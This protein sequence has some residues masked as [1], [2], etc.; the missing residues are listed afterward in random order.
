MTL[1]GEIEHVPTKVVP[2]FVTGY[3]ELETPAETD[4]PAREKASFLGLF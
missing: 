3:D 4:E 2:F 1:P